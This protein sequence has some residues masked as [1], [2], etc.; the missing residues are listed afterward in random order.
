MSPENDPE[1]VQ[2]Q[3]D[4]AVLAAD[5]GFIPTFTCAP[6]LVAM[7]RSRMR[8]WRGRSRLRWF[9]P[10]LF[11]VRGR[12]GHGTESAIAASLLGLVPEFGRVA[13]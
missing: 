7:C 13:G 1:Q 12:R 11:W 6:Y 8:F 10:I 4:L 5:A 9:M 2:M 3:K